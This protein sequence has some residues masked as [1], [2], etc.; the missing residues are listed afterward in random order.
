[1]AHAITSNVPG[2]AEAVYAAGAHVLGMHAMAPLVGANLNVTAV[3]YASTFA[4]G[5]VACPDNVEDVA[6]IARAIEDV[7]GELK[8]AAEEKRGYGAATARAG[9]AERA[10]ALTNTPQSAPVEKPASALPGIPGR[11]Q[12]A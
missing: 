10:V 2:P 11:K 4:V 6:S 8:I 12:P 5:L 9:L 1:M 3:S 7:V